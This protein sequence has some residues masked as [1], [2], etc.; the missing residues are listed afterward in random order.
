V[1]KFP[2]NPELRPKIARAAEGISIG[3][4]LVI[5]SVFGSRAVGW[6]I[7]SDGLI[8]SAATVAIL[9]IALWFGCRFSLR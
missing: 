3:A 5:W 7:G 8:D 4:A 6:P 1:I 2:G 9:A